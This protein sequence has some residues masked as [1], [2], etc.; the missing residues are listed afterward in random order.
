[1]AAKKFVMAAKINTTYISVNALALLFFS[2]YYS[3]SQIIFGAYFFSML[4]AG[5]CMCDS[6]GFPERVFVFVLSCTGK[7]NEDYHT[8]A[9]Y[10][11]DQTW[12]PYKTVVC[13]RFVESPLLL[14]FFVVLGSYHFANGRYRQRRI[15]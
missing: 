4:L 11:N 1:M 9:A 5:W 13:L 7:Q 6:F 12:L 15:P 3:F 14:L 2:V 8:E 10:R